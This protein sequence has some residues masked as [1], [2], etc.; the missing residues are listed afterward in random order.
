MPPVAERRGRPVVLPSLHSGGSQSRHSVVVLIQCLPPPLPSRVGD[1]GA[2]EGLRDQL[3]D[4]FGAAPREAE[5]GSAVSVVVDSRDVGV[6]FEADV[7][8]AEGA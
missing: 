6:V 3:G 8:G 4:V 5:A 7:V 2:R 1:L